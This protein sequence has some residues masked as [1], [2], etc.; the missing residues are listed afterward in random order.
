MNETNLSASVSAE[1]TV[2]GRRSRW[3][4]GRVAAV[5]VGGLLVLVALVLLGA[6]GTV[7]WADQTQRDDGYVTTDV[8][9]FST[10]GSALAT[11]E[12]QLGSAGV[13]WLYSPHLL[14]KIRI[15]VT[16]EAAAPL[17]VGIARS[18]DVD[19]YLAGVSHTLISDFFEG[20]AKLI[21]GS[22]PR[23]TPGTQHLWVASSTGP[24][25][26]SL[27]W[28]PRKG[29]WAVVVMNA[30]ARPGIGVRA[31]LGARFPAALWFAIGLLVA[32]G[33]FLAGG[34]LLIVGAI[35]ARTKIE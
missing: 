6:G 26:R 31:D 21:G 4:A 7:V 9:G 25:T 13:G 17:F 29:T 18:A 14:G 15:R 3:T 22:K 30:D 24:G 2:A 33:V 12:T 10:S 20:K 27:V 28:S 11:E 23:S 5:V 35:R 1:T 16:P 32:G 8:H 34:A 19:R